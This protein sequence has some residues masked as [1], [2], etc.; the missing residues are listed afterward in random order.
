MTIT[1]KINNKIAD[2]IEIKALMAFKYLG[3]I[4]IKLEKW[5]K[6]CETELS[7]TESRKNVQ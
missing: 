6:S 5:E 1:I 7:K 4:L 2:G 3:S